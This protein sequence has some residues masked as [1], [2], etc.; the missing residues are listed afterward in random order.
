M[1]LRTHVKFDNILL[2]KLEGRALQKYKDFIEFLL[3]IV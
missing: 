2:W 1:L 3:Y